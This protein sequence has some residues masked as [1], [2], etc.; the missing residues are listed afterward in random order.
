MCY[1][2]LSSIARD[3]QKAGFEGAQ[4]LDKKMKGEEIINTEIVINATHIVKRQSTNILAI[5][6]QYV[7]DAIL[8]IGKNILNNI[9]VEDVVAEVMISRRNLDERF[10]RALN[11]TIFE[12]ITRRRIAKIC[13]MLTNTHLTA[14]QIA[15]ECGFNDLAQMGGYFLRHKGISP[16][17]YRKQYR[18][19]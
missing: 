4:L 17:Q 15:Y 6:D 3:A 2:G 12:T 13:D 16:G 8:F 14:T 1:S 11:Q 9:G 5:K 18:L 7:R 19:S 10:T